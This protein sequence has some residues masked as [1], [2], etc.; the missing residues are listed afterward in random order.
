[1]R[2]HGGLTVLLADSQPVVRRGLRALLSTEQGIVVVAEAGTGREVVREAH[3]RRPDVVVLD[4][5]LGQDADL[6][7]IEDVRRTT[8]GTAVLVFSPVADSGRVSAA[9]RAGARGYLL[10]NAEPADIVRAVRGLAAGEV[11]FGAQVA[12]QVTRLLSSGG[13]SHPVDGLTDRERQVLDLIAEGMG[14]AAIARRL[15]VTPK[16]VSNHISAIFSK[17]Q[18]TDRAQAIARH[19]APVSGAGNP[20]N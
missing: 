9:M 20:P 15:Q 8:P 10:K 18:V 1:M 4:P 16:T 11:I 13:R 19:G 7:V 6:T 14:N 12:P 3:L 5:Q 17:L 2:D